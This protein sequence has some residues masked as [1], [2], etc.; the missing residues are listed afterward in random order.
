MINDGMAWNETKKENKEWKSIDAGHYG[1][2]M[3]WEKVIKRVNMDM[4]LILIRLNKQLERE[5]YAKGLKD[6]GTKE[7]GVKVKNLLK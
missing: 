1:S 2:K 6:G 5:L 7:I 4:N 3:A